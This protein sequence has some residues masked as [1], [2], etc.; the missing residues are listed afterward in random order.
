MVVRAACLSPAQIDALEAVLYQMLTPLGQEELHEQVSYCLRELAENA[1]R[2]VRKRRVF[3]RE[4]LDIA[5]PEDYRKGL[6]LLRE[7]GAEDAASSGNED[8]GCWVEVAIAQYPGQIGLRVANTGQMVALERAR[9]AKRLSA[10]QLYE[11]FDEVVEQVEDDSE[12]AGLGLVM[13]GMILRR[14]GV[15][16]SGFRFSSEQGQTSF[17]I[18]LPLNLVSDE[19]SDTLSEALKKEI[20]SI[21]QVPRHIH[22]LRELLR[23]T[24]H[25]FHALAK[26]IRKDPALTLEV[27]RM[28]NSPVYRRG[29]RIESCEVAL[30]LLGIR[31]L[32]GILDTFGAR[33]ALEGKYSAELLDRL[34]AH[35][36]EIAE[37]A[38]AIGRELDFP[39]DVIEGAYV[40]GLLH[41]MGKILL[42]GRHPDAYRVLQQH[43][44]QKQAPASA[45]ESLIA[46]VNHVRIG[47]RMAEH[48][49]LPER[50]VQAIR[51]SR[52]PLSA[53]P[54]ARGCAQLIYMAHPLLHR[55]EG[56]TKE[57]DVDDAVLA[58]FGV[59]TEGGWE[60]LVERM[61]RAKAEAAAS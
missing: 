24:E 33:K 60:G 22:A 18:V 47:A 10:A 8:D 58:S 14:L 6:D 4:G 16:E 1:V 30:R 54:A 26:L 13:L 9:V 46:G 20:D 61:G 41:D 37:M 32:R 39:D 48:W 45:V 12:S 25:N 56:S 11:T 29:Q 40:S 57:Y 34:W 5:K 35:S 38:A 28:A 2:A 21:P 17:E 52:A 23:D 42:E 55:L 51:Y 44:E 31:G 53:N 3:R 15:P 49:E 7:E 50:L 59:E 19:E 36:A 43:C 27:L